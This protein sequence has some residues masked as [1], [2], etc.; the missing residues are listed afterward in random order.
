MDAVDGQS[1]LLLFGAGLAGGIVTA[2]VGGS[3]LITFPALLAAGLPPIVANASNAVATTPGNIAAGF[4]DLERLPRWDRSF[5]GVM[6]ACVAGSAAG[7]TLLLVT[8][9]R[10]FTAAV[11]LLIGF[12]TA[13]FALS[14]R[15]RRWIQSRPRAAGRRAST[16][17]AEILPFVPLAIY[18]GYFGAGLSV[19]LL[20]VLSVTRADDLRGINVIKNLLAGLTG[21]VAVAVFIAKGMVA[22]TPTVLVMAGAVLGGVL[23]ARLAR[24]LPPALV[25]WIVIAVGAVLTAVY[26]WRAWGA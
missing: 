13:I 14:G 6:L 8:P 19:M 4:A 12:A 7:A 9:E 24:V 15:I 23:G 16:R 20:A 25:R 18:G 17:G 11:P 5:V 10:A 22:W 2:I 1:G 26:A 3:S 21:L